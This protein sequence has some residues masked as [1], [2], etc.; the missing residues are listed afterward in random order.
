[1]RASRPPAQPDASRHCAGRGASIILG[2]AAALLALSLFC[3]FFVTEPLAYFE[4]DTIIIVF[5]LANCAFASATV[6]LLVQAVRAPGTGGVGVSRHAQRL[7]LLAQFVRGILHF[8]A[9]DGPL[10][11]GIWITL[12]VVVSVGAS[13]ALAAALEPSIG[14]YM[15]GRPVGTRF[16]SPLI[17]RARVAI[18]S[19]DWRRWRDDKYARLIGFMCALVLLLYVETAVREGV[20][21]PYASHWISLALLIYIQA[22]AMLPQR[23]LLL[24]TRVLPTSTLAA[25]CVHA[26]GVALRMSM[27]LALMLEGEFHYGLMAGDF[28]HVALLVDFLL[29]CAKAVS[30]QGIAQ[31]LEGSVRIGA[32]NNV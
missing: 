10:S 31:V 24:R 1:M 6:L 29:L 30:E 27:W 20:H 22:A 2:G 19:Q 8:A 17:R 5:E 7:N 26:L 13:A 9:G 21:A 4:A 18:A 3:H 28:I 14:T 25:F 15:L 12:E 32:L 23:T 16:E 11:A